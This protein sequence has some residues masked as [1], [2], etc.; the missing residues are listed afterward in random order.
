MNIVHASSTTHLDQIVKTFNHLGARFVSTFMNGGVHPRSSTY[1]LTLPLQNGNY[2]KVFCPLDHTSSDSTPFNT[3]VSRRA[4][5]GGDWL[6]WV[7]TVYAVSKI[8]IVG[9]ELSIKEWPVS[10]LRAPI[11]SDVKVE[12]YAVT[13]SESGSVAYQVLTPIRVV[14]LD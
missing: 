3:A 13:E 11:G 8:K 4:L 14:R 5:K 9:D 6:T 10:E 2:K 1:G 12:S 7:V